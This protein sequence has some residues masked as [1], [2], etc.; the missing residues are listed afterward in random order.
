MPLAIKEV[1]DELDR[2]GLPADHRP[3]ENGVLTLCV[4]CA[5]QMALGGDVA[6]LDLRAAGLPFPRRPECH[7]LR[8]PLALQPAVQRGCQKC[9]PPM[10]LAPLAPFG[11]AISSTC[12][13]PTRS[14]STGSLRGSSHAGTCRCSSAAR[15]PARASWRLRCLRRCAEGGGTVA[16]IDC[17]NAQG[18][19]PGL[20]ERQAG[21]PSP[22][23]SA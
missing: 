8:A 14:P 11:A 12:S 10:A 9:Q 23:P 3:G 18:A 17:A 7:R 13:R 1:L 6:A 22:R 21:D 16:G 4:C 5:G 15:R 2:A 19:L 20:R